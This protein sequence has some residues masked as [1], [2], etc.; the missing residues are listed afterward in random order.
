MR[1]VM[2]GAG[3]LATHLAKAL[4]NAGNEIV[5]V[6][7]RTMESA[8]LLAEYLGCEAT[9]DLEKVVPQADLYIFSVKDSVLSNLINE[10]SMCC[11]G[12]FVHTA[13]SVP[14]SVFPQTIAHYGVLYPMQ[15]FSKQREVEFREIPCFLESSD[16]PTLAMLHSLCNTISKTVYEL[17]S[18]S[19]CHLHLAAVFA[20][21]FANHCYDIAS[22]V[23]QSQHI[24]FSCM[25]PLIR[26]TV[27]KVASLS[28]HNAQ[29]GPAVRYDENVMSAQEKLLQGNPQW[30]EIYKLMSKDIHIMAQQHD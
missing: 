17:S 16:E 25:L 28:P 14:L 21:N 27:E 11:Q 22:H 23:L 26:E 29:T 12:V 6:Y 1:I 2:I 20:S 18:E 24:P 5:Q 13:G 15:T 19:R 7:S 8:L 4:H 10:L 30:Q 3:N 9:N